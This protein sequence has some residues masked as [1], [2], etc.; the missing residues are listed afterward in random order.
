MGSTVEAAVHEHRNDLVGLAYRLLGSVSDAE[1][2]VQE[3]YLRLERHGTDGV[4]NV[5]GWLHRTTS[6]V[7]LD[8]LRSA[9][10]RREVYVGPWLPEPISVEV[11]P[12]EPVELAESLTMAFLVVLESLNPAERVAFVLREVFGYGYDDLAA[13]LDRSEEAC[14]KLV[15][16]AR[17]RVR[18]RRPRFEAD[19]AMRHE[20]AERFVD[21]CRTGDLAQ[22]LDVLAPDVVL[23]SDGGGKVSAARRP[24]R[25]VDRVVRFL[26]GVGTQAPA[27]TELRP[28]ALNGAPGFLVRTPDGRIDS[29]WAVDVADGRIVA[30]NAVRNPDKLAHLP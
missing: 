17:S 16:R 6:R 26:A 10:A 7:C 20:V 18:T 5:G 24:I 1:D 13:V 30:I 25:G 15:S 11:D 12:S 27:G 14:R 2:A 19:G 4:G 22:L 3:A 8:R 23:R 21:A 28:T 9:H 29:A